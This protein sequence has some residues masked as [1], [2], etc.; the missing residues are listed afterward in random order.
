[1]V[2]ALTVALPWAAGRYLRQQAELVRASA[3]H[4]R[5]RERARIARDMHDTLGHEL[6]LL[7]LRAGTLELRADADPRLRDAAGEV[8]AGAGAATERLAEIIGV[9]RDGEPAPLRPVLAGIDETV[10]RAGR[11]GLSAHLEWDGPRSLPPGVERSARRVVQEALT[12][13]MRH[14]PGARVRVR[15]ATADG[16]TVVTVTNGPPAR[17]ASCAA[18]PT[19]ENG[20]TGL[21]GLR[22]HARDAG[23]DLRAGPRDGGYEVVATLPHGAAP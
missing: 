23:G 4:A 8:R 22:E 21:A 16:T 11:A 14:A 20:G 10:H 5:L 9:L 7:A 18:Q 2:L 3:D 19:V 13:V 15:L 17:T 1:V 12:N 6:S